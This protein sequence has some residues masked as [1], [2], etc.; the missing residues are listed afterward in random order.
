LRELSLRFVTRAVDEQLEGIVSERGLGRLRPVSERVM[1][2]VDDRRSAGGRCA[3][4]RCWRRPWAP[5]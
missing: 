1:V 3:A 4:G 2:L 5:A